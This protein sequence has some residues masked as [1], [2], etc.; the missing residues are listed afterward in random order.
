MVRAIAGVSPQFRDWAKLCLGSVAGLSASRPETTVAASKAALLLGRPEALTLHWYLATIESTKDPEALR[1]VAEALKAFAATLD[2]GRA[3]DA[4]GPFLAAIKS[5]RDPNALEALAEGLG[6]LPV[7]LSDRQAKEAIEPFLDALKETSIKPSAFKALAEGLKAL[8]VKPDDSQTREL[9]KQFLAITK[10]GASGSDLKALGAG[11]KAFTTTLSESQASDAVAPL[12][13]AMQSTKNPSELQVLAE[14]LGALP[15]KLTDSQ[16]Q[17]AVEPFLAAIWGS[18]NPYTLQTL[19]E[20]LSALPVK[21]SDTQAK[22]F[23]EPFVVALSSNTGSLLTRDL[24]AAVEALPAR[25]EVIKPLLAAMNSNT[26][27]F[28]Q[29][30]L[31][32]GMR[33]IAKLGEDQAMELVEPFLT[34]IEASI[35][36]GIANHIALEGLVAAFGALPAR[37]DDRQAQETIRLFV[38]ESQQASHPSTLPVELKVMPAKLD[39]QPGSGGRGTLALRDPRRDRPL[40]ALG[41][42]CWNRSAPDRAQR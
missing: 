31:G 25:I 6:A 26:D 24:G 8:P 35:N 34:A 2:D 38:R 16:A 20:G 19:A 29:Y 39:A 13:T 18:T 28:S 10:G 3:K 36:K 23:A 4:A 14:G 7:K 9:V 33:G 11:L 37:L 17:E 27:P 15:A 30:A 42:G 5:T 21:L 41:L 40:Y 12:L 22:E 1:T 32:S